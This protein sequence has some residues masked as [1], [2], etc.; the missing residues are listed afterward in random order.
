[1]LKRALWEMSGGCRSCIAGALGSAAEV[2][3]MDEPTAPPD[4]I[5]T[6]KD[7]GAKWKA[8]KDYTIKWVTT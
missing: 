6:S 5:S 2:L 8:E 4:P 7:R 1:M 3:L